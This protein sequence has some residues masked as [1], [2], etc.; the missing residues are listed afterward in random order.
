MIKFRPH[1][2]Q[3]RGDGS[4]GSSTEKLHHGVAPASSERARYLGR[5]ALVVEAD[6]GTR[7]LCRGL[8][9]G[10]GFTVEAIDTGVAAV[11]TACR[12]TPDVILLDLQLRDV[13]GLEL[14]KWLRSNRALRSVP[15]IAI[16]ALAIA[17]D[18]RRLI[19]S[20]VSALLRKP[21]SPS[22]IESAIRE[23]LK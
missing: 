9:E 19:E 10:L 3:R 1:S 4:G 21:V 14:V 15:M 23:V 8:L 16:S 18:D 11:T 5:R 2:L 6:L 22:M 17:R 20:G 7:E 13:P 12:E